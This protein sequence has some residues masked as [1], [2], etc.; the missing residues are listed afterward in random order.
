MVGHTALTGLQP[1]D[2]LVGCPDEIS[3]LLL[4]K[5]KLFADFFKPIL[6]SSIHHNGAE[7]TT[8]TVVIFV[9]DNSTTVVEYLRMTIDEFLQTQSISTSQLAQKLEVSKETVRRYANG[10]RTPTRS[11]MERIVSITEGAVTPNDF[12]TGGQS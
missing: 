8:T 7:A 12:Y 6:H 2:L 9:V 10:T 11:V 5:T 4:G 3:E 1:L